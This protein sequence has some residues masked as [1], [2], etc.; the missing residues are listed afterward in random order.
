MQVTCPS[1]KFGGTVRDD[2]IPP[3]GKDVYCPNCNI[4][5]RIRGGPSS[6][7]VSRP[8]RSGEGSRQQ[9]LPDSRPISCPA[10]GLTG[11]IKRVALVPGQTKI[12]TCPACRVSFALTL[13]DDGS[14][15]KSDATPPARVSRKS[16]LS[17]PACNVPVP[18]ALPVCPSCGKVLLGVKITCPS[19]GSTNVGIDDESRGNGRS[20]GE[21][22]VFRPTSVA[23][24]GLA[25]ISIPLSCRDCGKT[26]TVQPARIESTEKPA[27]PHEKNR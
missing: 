7:S 10:C 23:A 17:C 14:T 25:D 6:P 1:C 20:E 19:C 12:I 26:W 5:F 18:Q 21:T 24:N 16:P 9:G 2:Q 22:L 13:S 3:E 4:R 27:R 8:P 15:L 11:K